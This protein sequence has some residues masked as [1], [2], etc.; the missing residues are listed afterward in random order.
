M[1]YIDYILPILSI[2]SGVEQ[3]SGIFS[4]LAHNLKETSLKINQ[5]ISPDI[6]T[7]GSYSLTTGIPAAFFAIKSIDC[8]FPRSEYKLGKIDKSWK[9]AFSYL[10]DENDLKEIK[11]NIPKYSLSENSEKF[12]VGE[13]F[14]RIE[15]QNQLKILNQYYTYKK[16][17][18]SL[19][20]SQHGLAYRV[21]MGSLFA[22]ISYSI[23]THTDVP[24]ELF[25]SKTLVF[26]W[27]TIRASA[28]LLK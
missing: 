18:D 1:A 3:A 10:C 22:L 21:S 23:D 8:F 19:L 17:Y 20:K 9:H 27:F 4:S 2:A 28:I 13:E 24:N 25:Q 14:K 11:A 16:E 5:R 12:L 15:Q 7:L 6:K 26:A